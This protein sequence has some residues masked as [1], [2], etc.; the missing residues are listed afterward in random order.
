MEHYTETLPQSLLETLCEKGM[1]EAKR[2]LLRGVTRDASSIVDT[3][4]YGICFEWFDNN[5]I[6]VG[7]TRDFKRENV[8]RGYVWRKY[9]PDKILSFEELQ[10]ICFFCN[11]WHEAANAAIEK[12]LTLI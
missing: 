3:P 8:F 9:T 10:P 4:N 7:V 6:A 5:G 1:L 12:A 2:Y 11:T